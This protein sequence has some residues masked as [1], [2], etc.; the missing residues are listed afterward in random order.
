LSFPQGI[1]F[2]PRLI[3]IPAGNLF[4]GP[5]CLS[6]P[7]GICFSPSP[8]VAPVL[9]VILSASFEREEPRESFHRLDR[10]N[11]STQKAV[12]ALAAKS[13]PHRGFSR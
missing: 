6:F 5:V 7:Q 9:A 12:F 4:L 2:S 10:S 13:H 8:A 11:L 3:V 1:C